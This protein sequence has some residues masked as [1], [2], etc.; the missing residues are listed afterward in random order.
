M[1]LPEFIAHVESKKVRS[2]FKQF[3]DS[4]IKHK[5]V[6]GVLKIEKRSITHEL[7]MESLNVPRAEAE[8]I[9]T[10][11]VSEGWIEAG[12]FIPTM[13]GMALAQHVDRPKISL[14]KADAIINE[15]LNW[16]DGV[17]AELN[18]RVRV[19]TIRLYGS[20][21]QRK[22]EVS[23]ID[24]FVEFTTM[25]L[26]LDLQPEDWEREEELG[27]ELVGISEYISPSP[28][29]NRELMLEAKSRLIFPRDGVNSQS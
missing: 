5:F 7:I 17:N 25:D 3:V 2:M 11:L 29:F 22:L 26:G 13:R 18:A 6:D 21:E 1:E 4:E 8:T 28:E 9:R 19:K 20:V 23:D 10:L 24:L 27:E 15:V 14:E 12:K 16:A